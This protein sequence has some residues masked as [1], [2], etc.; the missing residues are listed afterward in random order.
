MTGPAAAA[1]TTVWTRGVFETGAGHLIASDNRVVLGT[2]TDSFTDAF[3][4]LMV[5][6]GVTGDVRSFSMEYRR[7]T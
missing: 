7:P 4:S 6:D 1:L 2:G 5:L 3:G